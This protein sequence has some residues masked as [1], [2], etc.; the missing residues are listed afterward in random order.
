MFHFKNASKQ[1]LKAEYNRIAREIGDDQFFTKKDLNHLPEILMDS[2]Q[3]L[4]FASGV[5]DGTQQ[6]RHHWRTCR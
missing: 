3:V 6:V 1:A 2:E 4:A 5:M